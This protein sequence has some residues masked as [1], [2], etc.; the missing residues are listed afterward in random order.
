[1]VMSTSY[2]P[3]WRRTLRSL[4]AGAAAL[5][6]SLLTAC[7][8]GVSD[9][10]LA[11]HRLSYDGNGSTHGSTPL[12]VQMQTGTTTVV[13]TPTNLERSGHAFT[14][15]NTVS[16]GT[17]DTYAAGAMFLMGTA[18]VTLYA[19]W[20]AVNPTTYTVTYHGNT[21][22]GGTAPVDNLAY[23][24]GQTVSVLGAGTLEKTGHVFDSW[25]TL[26]DGEGVR[27]AAA[28]TFAMGNADFNL[29]AQWVPEPVV[30][31]VAGDT[32]LE[33][34]WP[35]V[36]D[37]TEYR[38]Y[39]G[40][41]DDVE[42]ATLWNDTSGTITAR[43]AT[44]TGLVNT[45]QYYVWVAGMVAGDETFVNADSATGT[46]ATGT[47]S[48]HAAQIAPSEH[49]LHVALDKMVVVPFNLALDANTVST[50]TVT[51]DDG[52]SVDIVVAVGIGGDTIEITP[53]GGVWS[54]ATTYTVT[55]DEA[56]TAATSETMNAP[57]TFTFTT[58][59]TAELHARWTWNNDGLDQ[60]GN[61]RDATVA[62]VTYDNVEFR[63]GTHALTTSEAGDSDVTVAAFDLG[64]TFTFTTWFHINDVWTQA[65]DPTAQTFFATG[66]AGTTSD[67]IK[68]YVDCVDDEDR[69]VVETGD[70]N[71]GVQVWTGTINNL[72]GT[73]HHLTVSVDRAESDVR[74]YLDGVELGLVDGQF[75][76]QSHYVM[77]NFGNNA[78]LRL[79]NMIDTAVPAHRLDGNVDDVRIYNR[80]FTAG[81]ARNVARER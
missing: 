69:I 66:E 23:T 43:T 5:A 35:A 14:N 17:G 54:A 75:H 81:E 15:W 80:L 67:G 24:F 65:N 8:S 58:L 76:N 13:S 27:Y 7:D 32:Q 53:D 21:N 48:V 10:L 37:A 16:N 20:Q 42:V 36:T 62:N 40:T 57:F 51:V 52:T 3:S 44:V 41:T 22:S 39:F 70:G 33:L 71:F 60:S 38:V 68:V 72:Y 61:S 31:V 11:E 1:M 19:Q 56:V 79:N 47:L 29:Y 73:W 30:T 77:P 59:D 45:T 25:N 28:A 6:F 64:E 26:A 46:P 34:S 55:I 49:A 12:S 78:T 18:D 4:V 74:I 2:V 50:T 63:E 9:A